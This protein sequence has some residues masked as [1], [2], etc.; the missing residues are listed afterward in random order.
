MT[1]QEITLKKTFDWRVWVFRIIA[2]LASLFFLAISAPYLLWPWVIVLPDMPD[3]ESQRWFAA[4]WGVLG[5]FFWALPLMFVMF[6]PS[7]FVNLMQYWVIGFLLISL[8]WFVVGEKTLESFI[9]LALVLFTY[10]NLRGLFKFEKSALSKKLA[11]LGILAILGCLPRLLIDIN[12][13][14]SLIGGSAEDLMVMDNFTHE[15]DIF[16]YI[17]LGVIFVALK[18][19]NWKIM[20]NII[21]A[22]LVYSGIAALFTINQAGSWGLLGGAVALLWGVSYLAII[23]LEA[24]TSKDVA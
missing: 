12:N 10:P 11:I 15:I 8:F 18:H 22:A 19:S 13:T 14:L 20:G 9:I 4:Q 23:R 3:P 24:Q 1:T 17:T 16:L 2:G 5:T 6:K 7:K 21:G